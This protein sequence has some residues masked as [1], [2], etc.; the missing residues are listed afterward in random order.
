MLEQFQLIIVSKTC[1]KVFYEVFCHWYFTK[2]DL[3]SSTVGGRPLCRESC[4][5][6]TKICKKELEM[7]KIYDQDWGNIQCTDFKYR[8]AGDN[9]ECYYTRELNNETD[10]L[11][12][13]VECGLM[14]LMYFNV[15]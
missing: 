10:K 3:T 4:E 6:A 12:D 11:Q 8:N 13:K 15:F 5:Y 2:C 7:A 1:L 14:F 9:P